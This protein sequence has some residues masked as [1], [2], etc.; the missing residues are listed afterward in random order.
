MTT[1]MISTA[2]EALQHY[3]RRA[4][5][6]LDEARTQITDS[7]DKDYVVGVHAMEKLISA[8]HSIYYWAQVSRVIE[9]GENES[10][11]IEGLRE[12]AGK[13]TDRLLEGGRSSSTSLVSNAI[14]LSAED[15]QKRVLRDVKQFITY[16][17]SQS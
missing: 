10:Q 1:T 13:M 9:R 6:D 14:T 3:V 16:V 2:I 7:F 12:W 4:T 5:Q 15:E 8:Q 17:D 11:V